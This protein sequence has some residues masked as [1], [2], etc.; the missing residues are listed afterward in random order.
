MLICNVCL[1]CVPKN[2]RYD[3]DMGKNQRPYHSEE[4]ALSEHDIEIYQY[5]AKLALA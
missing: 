1:N 3:E 2:A 5:D 4:F